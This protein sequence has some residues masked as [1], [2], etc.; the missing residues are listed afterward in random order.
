MRA[1]GPRYPHGGDPAADSFAA[2][3]VQRR[4]RDIGAA[5]PPEP[6]AALA[7]AD[8]RPDPCQAGVR[9]GA[10]DRDANGVGLGDSVL[11]GTTGA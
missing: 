9:G 4:W 1:D 11:T 10:D 7:G 8:G 2:G 5:T 6:V 3:A